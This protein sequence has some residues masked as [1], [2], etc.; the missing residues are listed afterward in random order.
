MN[1]THDGSEAVRDLEQGVPPESSAAIYEEL[2]ALARWH[3]NQQH[4]SHTLQPTALVHEAWMKLRAGGSWKSHDHFIAVASVA[5][6]QVLVD[7]ARRRSTQKRDGR[8]AHSGPLVS[9][10]TLSHRGFDVLA[11]D[12]LVRRLSDLDPRTG[13]IAHLKLFGGMTN[14][15]VAALI[16]VSAATVSNEWS[17]ARA[18]LLARLQGD[19]TGA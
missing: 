17:V 2:R 1:D 9:E 14:Q 4:A 16:E 5:M 19:G 11:I 6:R 3:F 18:W 12:D 13:R 7:H 15:Q 10:P 8:S